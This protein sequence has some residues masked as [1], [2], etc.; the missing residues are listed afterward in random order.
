MMAAF[1]VSCQ[2]QH[3]GQTDNDS[4][5]VT[6][7]ETTAEDLCQVFKWQVFKYILCTFILN[8]V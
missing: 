8:E 2:E 6:Y 4:S 1:A 5:A 3:E 7:A